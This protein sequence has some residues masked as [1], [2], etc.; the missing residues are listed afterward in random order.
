MD[1]R[2][3]TRITPGRDVI[4][5][6]RDSD[7]LSPTDLTYSLVRVAAYR[8]A[9]SEVVSVMEN[10]ALVN[11]G[12][13]ASAVGSVTGCLGVLKVFLLALDI[14]AAPETPPRVPPVEKV[15]PFL[16]ARIA[17]R[18]DS[19]HGVRPPCLLAFRHVVD[20][21]RP[22]VSFGASTGSLREAPD[23]TRP[24]V[25]HP[26]TCVSLWDVPGHGL[27]LALESLTDHGPP[28]I[29][30]RSDPLQDR[31]GAG[32]RPVLGEFLA[33]FELTS[34]AC[35]N[36]VFPGLNRRLCAPTTYR[37][38]HELVVHRHRGVGDREVVEG[39]VV[40][41]VSSGGER[42]RSLV[43]GPRIGP[44]ARAAARSWGV[45]WKWDRVPL[46]DRPVQPGAAI[47]VREDSGA[48]LFDLEAT[49]LGS[50]YVGHGTREM[51][52]GLIPWVAVRARASADYWTT[53]EH[54]R[55][56]DGLDGDRL[57]TV[58]DDIAVMQAR[59]ME[60]AL[61][62]KESI[63]DDRFHSWTQ[64][65]QLRALM[66]GRVADEMAELDAELSEAVDVVEH[67]LLRSAELRGARHTRL[68][69]GWSAAASVIA[70]VALFAALAAVPATSQPTLFPHWLHAL[71][72]SIAL[73]LGI[74]IAVVVW[75]R[76]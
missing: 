65:T 34:D 24:Y 16:P 48:V 56:P 44:Q 49:A 38:L 20:P 68:A 15:E 14:E 32:L 11:S 60:R 12:V 6:R 67:A 51:I 41:V 61:L 33:P 63:H 55:H 28:L 76:P 27:V 47:A 52:Y 53:V 62:R 37:P 29:D 26:A 1:R 57:A 73:T 59:R 30:W 64:P 3:T 71:T 50:D 72:T 9:G 43:D 22:E 36:D 19:D 10:R 4:G 23:A 75:R 70:V 46:V 17:D 40:E 2:W 7:L 35:L 25:G 18:P 13:G 39:M 21:T 74:V 42:V 66:A 8:A 54:L 58:L 31:D 45:L 5:T 69:Q